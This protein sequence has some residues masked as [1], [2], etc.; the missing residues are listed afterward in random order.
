MTAYNKIRFQQKA[1]I[2]SSRFKLPAPTIYFTCVFVGNPENPECTFNGMCILLSIKWNGFFNEAI[3]TVL[4][5]LIFNNKCA[6][7]ETNN[8]EI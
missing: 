8:Y 4:G 6:Y 3:Q 7:F 2:N 5:E 1:D